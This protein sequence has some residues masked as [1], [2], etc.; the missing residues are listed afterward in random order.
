[1]RAGHVGALDGPGRL[2]PR[3]VGPERNMDPD[4][5][6]SD[7]SAVKVHHR[8]APAVELRV[9]SVGEDR[10]AAL[11]ADRG[12]AA[13]GVVQRPSRCPAARR[14]SLAEHRRPI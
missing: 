14:A 4:A 1:M 5:P 9:D 8:E 10:P 3:M 13:G 11:G 6:W 7:P 12:R 2:E